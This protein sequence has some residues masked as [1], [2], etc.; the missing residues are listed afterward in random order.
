MS[1][2]GG[3]GCWFLCADGGPPPAFGLVPLEAGTVQER[4]RHHRRGAAVLDDP[5]RAVS[6]V[7][8]GG[9]WFL[10]Q[11]RRVLVVAPVVEGVPG[12]GPGHICGPTGRGAGTAPVAW[13]RVSRAK[14]AFFVAK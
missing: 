13:R 14:W 6:S 11:G 3:G 12:E 7:G 5:R 2:V 10:M 1:S 9:C 8:G 4:G